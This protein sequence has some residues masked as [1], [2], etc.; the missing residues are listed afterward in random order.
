MLKAKNLMLFNVLSVADETPEQIS[1]I[2]HDLFRNLSV[3]CNYISTKRIGRDGPRPRPIV[4]ELCSPFDVRMVLKTKSIM[5]NFKQWNKVSIS[6][7][8]TL[9]QRK[10]LSAL[11][12]DL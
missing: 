2:L 6:E 11:R 10:Q 12:S 9:I 7:D 4:V 1:N 5:R 8:L 3:Q